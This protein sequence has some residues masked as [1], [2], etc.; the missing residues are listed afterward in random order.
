[1]HRTQAISMH[2]S[3][4]SLHKQVNRVRGHRPHIGIAV[5]IFKD[6]VDVHRCLGGVR[7]VGILCIII[8]YYL[9]TFYKGII[10]LIVS[11]LSCLVC[12]ASGSS[13]LLDFTLPT[14]V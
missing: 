9:G 2:S 5:D 8:G 3:W 11:S 4:I 14:P 6:Y 7:Y 1:M 10:S 13:P 12:T